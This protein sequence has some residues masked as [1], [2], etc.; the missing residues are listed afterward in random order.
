MLRSSSASRFSKS[1]LSLL[2]SGASTLTPAC[3]MPSSTGISGRSMVSYMLTM[4]SA[5]RRGLSLAQSC[6]AVSALP[7]AYS[8][9]RS[10]GTLSRLT[11]LA[12]EPASRT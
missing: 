1:A 5:A 11:C 6:R 4:H 9:A 2:S 3:S 10:I 12:P 8:R 7:A